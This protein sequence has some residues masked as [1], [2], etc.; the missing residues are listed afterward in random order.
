MATKDQTGSEWDHAAQGTDEHLFDSFA[1]SAAA[2]LRSPAPEDGMVGVVRKGNRQ[3]ATRLAIEVGVVVALVV[4]GVAVFTRSKTRERNI[5]LPPIP[6]TQ[7]TVSSVPTSVASDAEI[8]QWFLDYTGNPVGPA[9]GDPVKFGVVMPS[10]TYRFRLENAATYLN[11]NA[12]GVGGHPI[13]LDVCIEALAVCADRFAADPAVVAVVE[14]RWAEDSISAALAGRKPLHTTYSGSGTSGVDYYPTYRETVNAMLLQAEKLTIPGARVLVIDAAKE[15]Q[16]IDVPLLKAFVTPDVSA[17]LAN[18]QVVTVRASRSEFLADTIRR[19]GT[20]VAAVVLATPPI[21]EF[22]TLSTSGGLVCDDLAAALDELSI[23]PAVVVVDGCEPHDGWYQVDVGYNETSPDL[24]SGALPI[25]VNIP[26]LGKTRDVAAARSIREVGALL[27]V[28]RIINQLGGPAQA[29]PAALDQAMREFSGPLPLGAGA[30][31]CSATAH[32]AE[33]R[34]PGSC[35]R[36]VDVHQFVHDTWI[37]LE[38]ID[39]NA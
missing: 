15:Q 16:N 39:L 28:I 13:E 35:V 20:D 23:K 10:L 24:L 12:G 1:R 31:D 33:R 5:D 7:T 27:A 17:S 19:V 26:G 21:N 30:L 14:N 34:Q 22:L 29:T 9:S 38:P 8:S 36:Y 25:T 32:L 37:D 11:E 6:T 3:R 18:R 2:S 4:T